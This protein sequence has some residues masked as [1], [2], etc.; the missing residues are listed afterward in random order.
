MSVVQQLLLERVESCFLLPRQNYVCVSDRAGQPSASKDPSGPNAKTCLTTKLRRTKFRLYTKTNL[1][2]ICKIINYSQKKLC[3]PEKSSPS[4]QSETGPLPSP[5]RAKRR[6]GVRFR[7][8]LP[9]QPY[10]H[11]FPVPGRSQTF[12]K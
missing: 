4:R 3:G 5:E 6:G 10:A 11:G 1:C 12:F 2:Y 9:R 8:N 7:L